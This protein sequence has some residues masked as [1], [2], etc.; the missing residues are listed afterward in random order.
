MSK[1]KNLVREVIPPPRE[2]T[3]IKGHEEVESTLANALKAGRLAHALL[4]GGPKGIGK[5]TLMYRFARYV[6][7]T[8][9][10]GS[11][12]TLGER[13]NRPL[14]LPLKDEVFAR[15]AS[16]SHPDLFVLEKGINPRTGRSRGE[17]T[18]DEAR[19]LGR[20]LSLTPAESLWRIAIVDAADE[21]NRHAANA[22]LKSL[23][24]PPKRTILALISHAPNRL[25]PTIRS[26][27]RGIKLRALSK[28]DFEIIIKNVDPTIKES[29]MDILARLSKYSPGQAFLIKE[30]EGTQLYEQLVKILISAPTIDFE[31]VHVLADELAAPGSN[32]RFKLAMELL[33]DWFSSFITSAAQEI[34]LPETIEGE[35]AARERFIAA[36]GLDHWAGLWE[37]IS[38]IYFRAEQ[39]HLDRKQVLLSTYTAI[40]DLAKV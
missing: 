29:D 33:L 23:E 40:G 16:G 8:G 10:L 9:K 21:M 3:A 37:N 14:D 27:C 22:I 25:L 20:F 11:N 28:D 2:N 32:P 6:L 24:E 13:T 4:I 26:R 15:I 38:R 31:S 30:L 36:S 19:A 17:I 18:V 5:A 35:Q 12:A 1:K 34:T 7:S 39:V